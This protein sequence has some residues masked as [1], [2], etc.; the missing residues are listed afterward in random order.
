M[1]KKIHK[2]QIIC[3]RNNN[4]IH[5]NIGNTAKAVHKGKFLAFKE[6]SLRINNL[7]VHPQK[8]GKA[9]EENLKRQEIK[10]R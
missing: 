9:N 4:I 7:I 8:L 10:T 3:Q 5:Q 2:I 1:C 6:E